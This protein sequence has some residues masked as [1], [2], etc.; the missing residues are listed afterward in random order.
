MTSPTIHTVDN[1]AAIGVEWEQDGTRYQLCNPRGT[2]LLV[3]GWRT[4]QRWTWTTVDNPAY[5]IASD[6]T[7]RQV[8]QIMHR[9]VTDGPQ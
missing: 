7:M 9:Y 8:Q 6:A 1:P 3:L 5:A 2:T 4:D